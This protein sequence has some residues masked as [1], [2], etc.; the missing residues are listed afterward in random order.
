VNG[1]AYACEDDIGTLSALAQVLPTDAD[2]EQPTDT[3]AAS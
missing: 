1:D 2:D 3:A